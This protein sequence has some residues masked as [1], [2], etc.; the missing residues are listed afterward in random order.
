MSSMEDCPNSSGNPPPPEVAN[1]KRPGRTTNQLQYLENSVL[2]ALWRHQFSWPFC[3]P[4]DAVALHLPDYY[5]IIKNPMDMGTIK[6]RL[7]NKYYWKAMECVQDFNTMFTNCYVYNK[8]GDDIVHMA[9][10]LEK[11]FLLEIAKM[12]KDEC[13]VLQVV[14]KEAAKGMNSIDGSLKP[15]PIV[16]QM[17]LQQ[18]MTLVRPDAPRPVTPARIAA[19][20][21]ENL[22]KGIKRKLEPAPSTVTSSISEAP[23]SCALSMRTGSGRPV[24]VPKKDLAHLEDTRAKLP[25]PLR[26]CDAILKEMFSKRHYAYAWPF[27]T[28]VDTVALALHDYHDIIKQPMDLGSI[29]KKMELREYTSAEEFAADVR[30]MFSNCYKYNPPAHE[31]ANMARKLQE[32]FEARYA[33]V[34]QKPVGAFVAAPRPLHESKGNRVGS[35]ALSTSCSSSSSSSSKSN[36]SSSTESSSEEVTTQLTNLQ[37]KLQA[38]TAQLRRLTQDP[39]MNP[40][41]NDKL[42]KEKRAKEKD[43]ARLEHKSSNYKRAVENHIKSSA[44]HGNRSVAFWDEPTP[45]TYQEKKQLK[46]DLDALPPHKVAHIVKAC[47]APAQ[48]LSSKELLVDLEKMKTSTHKRLQR[49]VLACRW[50]KCG[51]KDRSAS[52]KLA[53]YVQVV[54]SAQSTGAGKCKVLGKRQPDGKKKKAAATRAS[55]PDF[56]CPSALSSSSSS[57]PTSCRSSS[58]SSSPSSDSGHSSS[59]A[60]LHKSAKGQWKKITI[61]AASRKLTHGGRSGNAQASATAAASKLTKTTKRH[62]G[63]EG[64]MTLP[65]PDLSPMPSPKTILVWAISGFKAPVLS[66][67]KKTPLAARDNIPS[68]SRCPEEVPG[69]Q[70]AD[71]SS[72]SNSPCRSTPQEK[73]TTNDIVLK[74]AESWARLVRQS[75][76]IPTAIKSSKESFQQFRKAAMEK[77]R[78]KALKMKQLEVPGKSLNL[79]LPP[80]KADLSFPGSGVL[81]AETTPHF[82]SSSGGEQPTSPVETWLGRAQSPLSRERELARRKEQERRRREAMSCIDITMQQDVMTTFELTLD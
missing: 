37:E 36:S 2:K 24:K 34:A 64:R 25:E 82:P 23:T 45:L 42:K 76:A 63:R 10:M 16:S 22:K 67:L 47:D 28:P 29:K 4:V 18:T 1:P 78:E 55:S 49:F 35:P 71:V 59:A 39:L 68:D 30:L 51:K 69:S 79:N 5:T 11:L 73:K 54:H 70:V 46:L 17:V 26:H 31:V 57:S 44:F 43:I 27:Y 72:S 41:K 52:G 50:K 75:A 13:E 20:V 58:N 19:Q 80:S 66:P 38:V 33:R 62:W 56:I 60:K 53:K 21:D 14:A 74:N 48:W 6:K 61:K 81:L 3:Q 77:E 9:Q 8:P 7:Q 12:P 15:R 32:V 40:K 65:L